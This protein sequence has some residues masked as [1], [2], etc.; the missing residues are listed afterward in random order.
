MNQNHILRYYQKRWGIIGAVVLGLIFLAIAM[1][2]PI[3]G[4]PGY[5]LVRAEDWSIV[6]GFAFSFVVG[7]VVGYGLGTIYGSR[8]GSRKAA[9]WRANPA[10]VNIPLEKPVSPPPA[11]R[12][13]SNHTLLDTILSHYPLPTQIEVRGNFSRV[14]SNFEFF[15]WVPLAEAQECADDANARGFVVWA[16]AD[17]SSAILYGAGNVAVDDLGST[18]LW[19]RS[20]TVPGQKGTCVTTLDP[21]HPRVVEIDSSMTG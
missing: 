7:A 10:S 18:I 16:N 3:D 8:V 1:L 6:W 12:P 17:A 14:D 20:I 4:V 19:L 13:I 15:T 2:Q 9:E 5:Q 11:A 21:Y